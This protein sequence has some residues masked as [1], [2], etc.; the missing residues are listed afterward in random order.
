MK[1]PRDIAVWYIGETFPQYSG[2]TVARFLDVLGL[3]NPT[4][5]LDVMAMLRGTLSPTGGDYRDVRRVVDFMADY[6]VTPATDWHMEGLRKW[7][8]TL[9]PDLQGFLFS[10]LSDDLIP[11]VEEIPFWKG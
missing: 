7:A 11:F 3:E 9:S 1:I 5:S 4:S 2:G 6:E 8:K 10:S